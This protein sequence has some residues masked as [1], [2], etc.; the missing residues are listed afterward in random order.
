MKHFIYTLQQHRQ[1]TNGNTKRTVTLYS[2]I[3]NVP[4]LLGSRSFYYE[5]TEQAVAKLAYEV[6]AI[7]AKYAGEYQTATRLENEGIATF[8]SI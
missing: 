8:H 4:A 3:K 2:V 7:P 6:K 1:D 5:S